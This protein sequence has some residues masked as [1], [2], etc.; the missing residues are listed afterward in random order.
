[1]TTL[2][3]AQQRIL[4]FRF[5]TLPFDRMKIASAQ[6]IVSIIILMLVLTSVASYLVALY[7]SFEFGFRIQRAQGVYEEVKKEVLAEEMLL[8]K[9]LG[10]LAE[11]Q[12]DIVE[13]MEKVSAIK[14]LQLDGIAS[15]RSI[16][17]P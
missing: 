3:L 16:I 10:F 1:M 13:S 15:S 7:L 8:Q 4:S 11:E 12:K 6:R 5:Y 17:Q 14:Y 9:G 2:L